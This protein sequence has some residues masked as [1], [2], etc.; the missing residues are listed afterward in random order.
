ML[1]RF[2]YEDNG[3]EAVALTLR[4]QWPERHESVD[5]AK[6]WLQKW[7]EETFLPMPLDKLRQV[8]LEMPFRR[9]LAIPVFF[10]VS[11]GTGLLQVR[12]AAFLRGNNGQQMVKFGEADAGDNPPGFRPTSV[13]SRNVG[14]E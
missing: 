14:V 6:V 11:D 12:F 7:L 1:V 10:D 13:L 8:E 2:E 4:D 5:A 3:F 9:I